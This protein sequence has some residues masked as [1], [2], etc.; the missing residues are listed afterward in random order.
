[1]NNAILIPTDFSAQSR[2]ALRFAVDNLASASAPT[3]LVLLNAYAN[4]PRISAPMISLHDILKRRSEEGLQREHDFVKTLLNGNADRID[5]RQVSRPDTLKKAIRY[6]LARE[7]V[8]MI[9]LG[10]DQSNRNFDPCDL[11]ES[12]RTPILLV[13]SLGAKN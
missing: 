8:Q 7:S 6:I 5:I 1:M 2:M 11:V 9:V 4:M 10:S 12:F 3:R 13:P